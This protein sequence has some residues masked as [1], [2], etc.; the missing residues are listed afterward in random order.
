MLELFFFFL[1]EFQGR[2]NVEDSRAERVMSELQFTEIY[3]VFYCMLSL[4][5]IRQIQ[6]RITRSA[7]SIPFCTYS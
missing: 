7:I 4:Y 1:A 3:D 5:T 2:L 6:A